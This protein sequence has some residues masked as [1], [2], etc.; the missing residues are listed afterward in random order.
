MHF[1][2]P[3]LFSCS[4]AHKG[5][6]RS[7]LMKVST[8]EVNETFMFVACEVR[9]RV[10]PIN[11]HLKTCRSLVS[12]TENHWNPQLVFGL[13]FAQRTSPRRVIHWPLAMRASGTRCLT[14]RDVVRVLVESRAPMQWEAGLSQAAGWAGWCITISV[15][16]WCSEHCLAAGDVSSPDVGGASAWS[17][18]SPSI[19][20]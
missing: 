4:S 5:V 3:K 2:E 18:C 7:P 11:L 20:C 17:V 6:D 12:G 14:S 10:P 13:L 9:A 15:L 8:H 19:L 16:I 1:N